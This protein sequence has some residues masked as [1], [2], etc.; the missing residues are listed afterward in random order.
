MDVIVIQLE[1]SHVR[2]RPTPALAPRTKGFTLVELLVVI[3]I[4]GVLITLLLPAV[5]AAREAARTM[6]CD[7]NLHQIGVALHNYHQTNSMFP[8]GYLSSFVTWAGFGWS[9]VILP[10]MEDQTIENLINFNAPAGSHDPVN[11]SAMRHFIPGYQCP[12]AL[13]LTLVEVSSAITNGPTPW[14]DGAGTNYVGV[15]TDIAVDY[16]W[17]VTAAGQ[18]SKS[19]GI[20]FINGCVRIDDI[21]D[22]SSQTLM[23]AERTAFPDQDPWYALAGAP[24]GVLG[25]PWISKTLV[26]TYWGINQQAG[27]YYQ[28]SGVWSASERGKLCVRRWPRGIVEPEHPCRRSQVVDDTQRLECGRRYH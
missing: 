20:F 18:A 26:T 25:E 9:A 14:Q 12:S 15:D 4:I 1:A 13:P 28:A 17:D 10:Y 21:H 19:S 11:G 27:L 24:P 7:N 6:A 16:C 3:V 5:Q 23:V 2:C 8:S 22:G